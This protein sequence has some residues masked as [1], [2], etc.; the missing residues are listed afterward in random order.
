MLRKPLTARYWEHNAI[1]F[2]VL[3][4]GGGSTRE[5][6]REASQCN[7]M[8]SLPSLLLRMPRGTG[9]VLRDPLEMPM[10]MTERRARVRKRRA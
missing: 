9:A 5:K 6:L 3:D 4:S 2:L 8:A 7:A 10:R 1:A